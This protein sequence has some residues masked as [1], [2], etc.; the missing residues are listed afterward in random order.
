MKRGYKTEFRL[1]SRGRGAYPQLLKMELPTAIVGYMSRRASDDHER[2]MLVLTDSWQEPLGSISPES[3]AN[4]GF[5]D[6]AHFR[7]YWTG[8]TKVR[9]RPLDVVQVFRVRPF[10][11]DDI[12]VV[13]AVLFQRLY[14]EFTGASSEHSRLPRRSP[15]AAGLR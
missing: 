3:L 7:R 8:R 5:A 10:T 11:P 4:E 6:F 12:A 2:H 15:M 13:G 9:F 14:G 1:T